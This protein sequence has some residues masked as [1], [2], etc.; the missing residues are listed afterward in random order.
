[1]MFFIGIF[2][3][4]SKVAP[5]GEISCDCCPICGK[6]VLLHVCRRYNYFHA[7]FLPLFRFGGS[8]LATCPSCASVFELRPE[9]GKPLEKG[10]RVSAQ[11]SDLHLLKNNL[12][13]HCPSCGA[14][15]A[16]GNVFCSQCGA[17]L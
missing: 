3:T 12:V 17:K 16:T 5:I 15:Q 9:L 10:E 8:Y 14:A 4:G 7:F 13:P 11:A 6:P 2:G 1:M